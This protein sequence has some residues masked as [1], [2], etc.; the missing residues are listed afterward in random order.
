METKIL[1]FSGWGLKV[2]KRCTNDTQLI[3]S[4]CIKSCP[5]DWLSKYGNSMF[6]KKYMAFNSE[7]ANL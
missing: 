7:N 2:H 5:E 3:I 4:S 1:K 6:G